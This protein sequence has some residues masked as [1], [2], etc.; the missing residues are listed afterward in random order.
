[1]GQRNNWLTIYSGKKEILV[2]TY[3]IICIPVYADI[4]EEFAFASRYFITLIITQV[5]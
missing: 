1:M 5:K 3:I 4:A 2:Y